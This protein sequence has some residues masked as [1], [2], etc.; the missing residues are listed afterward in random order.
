MDHW[1]LVLSPFSSS[2]RLCSLANTAPKASTA[3]Q[4]GRSA[5]LIGPESHTFVLTEDNT[6]LGDLADEFAKIRRDII[7]GDRRSYVVVMEG[8]VIEVTQNEENAR[9]EKARRPSTQPIPFLVPLHLLLSLNPST[10]LP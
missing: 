2:L 8:P 6:D 7:N 3:I 9:K 5:E 1:G 4:I 10:R